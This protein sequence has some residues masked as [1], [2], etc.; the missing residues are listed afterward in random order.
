LPET[1]RIAYLVSS[2]PATNHTFILREIVTL[3][4]LGFDIQVIAIRGA[5]RPD[6]EMTEVERLERKH[7]FVILPFGKHF[8]RAHAATAVKNPRGYAAGLLLALKL[9]RYNFRAA[10]F[11]FIYFLEAVVAGHAA[12][13]AGFQHIHSHFS[14][15]VALITARIFGFGLSITIHGPDEFR[16]TEEFGLR[17]KVAASRFISTI[18]Q[19]ARS[20]IML[21]SDPADWPKIE[22]CRLGVDP[23]IFAP[24][25]TREAPDTFSVICVGR[26]APVKAQRILI[27]ACSRLASSGWQL[28]LYLVGSGPDLNSLRK[29]TEASGMVGS[30]VFEG[31]RNQD[32]VVALYR[33]SDVFALASFGEGVPVVLMEAM[34]MQIPCIATW[35]NGIPELIRHREEGLLVAP[36][37]EEALAQGIEELFKSRELRQRLG[38]AGRIQVALHYDLR[39]NTAHLAEVFQKYLHGI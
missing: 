29:F 4:S 38:R 3:R 30:V 10:F 25:S 26:L 14:S 23:S 9:S 16:N 35:V 8:L 32:E 17:E 19:Y 27:A 36:S 1:I 2:Y 15:T 33:Q 34:A 5:D 18:S 11:H 39:R 6:S 21:A 20:Q 31:A 12:R 13:E 37:D 22:V 24:E 7:T 28:K